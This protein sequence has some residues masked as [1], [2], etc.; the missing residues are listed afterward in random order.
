MKRL[1]INVCFILLKSLRKIEEINK[2]KE[3]ISNNQVLFLDITSAFINVGIHRIEEMLS[4]SLHYIILCF[5]YV[6]MQN[7][8]SCK[9]CVCEY[10]ERYKSQSIIF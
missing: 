1:G 9:F 6:L 7:S 8:M 2:N 10:L 5:L 4:T 3:C